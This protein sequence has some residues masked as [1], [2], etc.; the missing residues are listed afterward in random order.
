LRDTPPGIRNVKRKPPADCH[1]LIRW[2]ELEKLVSGD[3]QKHYEVCPKRQNLLQIH[4]TYVSVVSF[5]RNR[6]PGSR[7]VLCETVRGNEITSNRTHL[8]GPSSNVAKERIRTDAA[9]TKASQV[10]P[11]NCN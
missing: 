1:V 6:H 9:G 8:F 11:A 2:S 5:D 7:G 10:G 4:V 3:E